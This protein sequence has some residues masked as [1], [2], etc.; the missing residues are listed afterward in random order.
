MARILLNEDQ[1]VAPV[2]GLE[3]LIK[4]QSFEKELSAVINHKS[5]IMI[6]IAS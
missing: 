5:V 6:Q 4:L 2:T 3:R 1:P